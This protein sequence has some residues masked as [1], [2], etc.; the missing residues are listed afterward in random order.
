MKERE[1]MPVKYLV[2]MVEIHVPAVP[3]THYR[4]KQLAMVT[5]KEPLP[6]KLPA[7]PGVETRV[8]PGYKLSVRHVL[9]IHFGPGNTGGILEGPAAFHTGC[10]PVAEAVVR[11]HAV[12]YWTIPDNGI[13]HNF[14]IRILASAEAAF[15]AGKTATLVSGRACTASHRESAFTLKRMSA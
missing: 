1:E 12:P 5:S 6:G 13:W 11:N 2:A 7:G 15:S 9:R 14:A 10:L 4:M 3:R 8:V